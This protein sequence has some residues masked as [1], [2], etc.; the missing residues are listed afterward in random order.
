M[1]TN[2]ELRDMK[3][4]HDE[5]M[6][7]IRFNTFIDELKREILEEAKKGNRKYEKKIVQNSDN[8]PIHSSRFKDAVC[9]HFPEIEISIKEVSFDEYF[10]KVSKITYTHD[11]MNKFKIE[12]D[13]HHRFTLD[14]SWET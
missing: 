5:K 13:K 4:Q 3:R 10:R 2:A 11:V 12:W 8:H 14:I 6:Y 1:T 7:N 9:E